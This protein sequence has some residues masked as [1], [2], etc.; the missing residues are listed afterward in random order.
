MIL[1]NLSSFCHS[2]K[3]VCQRFRQEIHF[4][5]TDSLLYFSAAL[6]EALVFSKRFHPVLGA[7]LRQPIF[8]LLVTFPHGS[9]DMEFCAKGGD[10]IAWQC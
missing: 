7:V 2:W 4:L 1:L 6:L 8:F 3:L 5:G 10:A 9:L